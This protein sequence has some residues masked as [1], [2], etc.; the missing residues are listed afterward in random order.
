MKLTIVRFTLELLAPLHIGSGLTHPTTDSPVIRDPFG[1]YRIPG[2]SLAGALRAHTEESAW[3]EAG[4]RSCASL[5]DISDGFLVD[6]DGKITLGK[7]L[8]HE[9]ILYKALPE[10]Q[11]HVRID[12][13]TGAA[14]EGGKFDAEIIPQGTRFRCELV[15]VER[16]GTPAEL[17]E[18]AR[19]SFWSALRT[20]Q[21]GELALGGDIS[22][23]L[24]LVHIVRDSLTL[25]IH[26][27]TTL[28]GVTAARNRSWNIDEPAG[29]E[30]AASAL[31]KMDAHSSSHPEG[32][33][34]RISLRFRTDGPLLVGGSQRPSSKSILDKNHGADLVFGESVLAD[35]ATRALVGRPWVPGSSIRG[36]IRHRTWHIFEA[37]GL[38]PTAAQS[39][40]DDL[41]GTI[42]S[43]GAR[44]SNVRFHGYFLN[45]ETRTAVQ[46]V[47]I[48]RLTG[49]SLL[50]A[51]FSEAPIW[52]DGLK[53]QITITLHGLGEAQAAVFAH[54]LI[55]MA[56]GEL[57][58][59]GGTR[60][61]NGRLL[62]DDAQGPKSW[63]GKAVDFTIHHGSRTITNASDPSIIN[64]FITQLDSANLLLAESRS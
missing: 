8:A 57:S 26:D 50:G 48:D 49:G 38:S 19:W 46:H 44:A 17:V 10:L 9:E 55:D 34:G 27:L 52:R 63:H 53:L 23:G 43:G 40:I 36:A 39:Q 64:A 5:I 7:R 61:G 59:G 16:S 21:S 32:I 33:S 25:G 1:D 54:A 22:S 4:P 30:D 28:A 24:G 15:L 62:L 3:G 18:A 56:Q 6:F 35:Y 2:S 37:L 42:N 58:I 13:N 41:F 14:I 47:A 20:L 45:D 12:H 60:R 29:V 51:L 11:E 31:A